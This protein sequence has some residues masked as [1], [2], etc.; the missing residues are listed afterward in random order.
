MIGK[1]IT[2]ADDEIIIEEAKEIRFN[3]SHPQ[4]QAYMQSD[5][6]LTP[7]ID[8][9]LTKVKFGCESNEAD[10]PAPDEN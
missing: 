4:H 7:R 8:C 2:I 1:E 3:E 5:K 10:G 9:P 6:T